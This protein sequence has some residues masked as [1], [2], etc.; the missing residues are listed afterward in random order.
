MF[1]LHSHY[2]IFF[3]IIVLLHVHVDA[4]PITKPLTFYYWTH[5]SQQ[6]LI[7]LTK[8]LEHRTIIIIILI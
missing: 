4:E 1:I 8:Y 7:P 3:V 5:T 2:C 6:T